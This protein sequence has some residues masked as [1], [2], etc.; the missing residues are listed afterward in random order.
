MSLTPHQ[1]QQ[2]HDD[3]YLL[4]P[5][6]VARVA[7]DAARAA[8]NHS[9]GYD[10]LPPDD[11]PRMRQQSYCPGLGKQP[12]MTDLL[13]RGPLTPMLESLLGDGQVIPVTSTQIALRFPGHGSSKR[14]L[15]GHIDGVG[16]GLNGIP[17]GEMRRG[18]TA[19]VTVLLADVLEPW[20]G[21]FTVWPGSHHAA[22][23]YFQAATPEQRQQ[24]PP[25]YELP[26]EPVQVCGQA[27]DAVITH[28]LLWHAAA[29]NHGPDIRYA[30]IFRVRQADFDQV[31]TAAHTDMWREWP[32][33]RHAVADEST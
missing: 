28:H 21:N 17:K 19:L 11:L 2:F 12:V 10:G 16:T 20:R 7:I 25:R 1:I 5:G 3:G 13:N 23:H 8:V 29:P 15:G 6:A 26:H 22:Q 30:A 4:I 24:V 31:G 18:F 14:S 9:L 32:G 27:G 33:V